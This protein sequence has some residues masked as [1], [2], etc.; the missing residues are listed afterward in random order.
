MDG[1][2]LEEAVKE[3]PNEEDDTPKEEAKEPGQLKGGIRL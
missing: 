1:K 2:A 3:E